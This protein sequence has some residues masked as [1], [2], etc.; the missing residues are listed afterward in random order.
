MVVLVVAAM[1]RPINTMAQDWEIS[2]FPEAVTIERSAAVDSLLAM[3]R[4]VNEHVGGTNGYRVQLFSGSGNESRQ[5]ANDVRNSFLREFPNVPAYLIFQSPNFKVRVGD[6]RTELEGLRLQ[7]DISYWFPG[8]FVVKDDIK[9]APP[10]G[11]EPP[12]DY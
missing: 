10:A 12:K 1:L 7:K 4:R 2:A 8:G 3:H 9:F 6:V 11:T 5:Q